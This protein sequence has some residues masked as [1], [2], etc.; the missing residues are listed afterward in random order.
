[1]SIKANIFQRAE[2]PPNQNDLSGVDGRYWHA[3]E[4]GRIQCDLCPRF[5]RLND[6]QRGLCFVRARDGDKLVLHSS[7]PHPA[8]PSKMMK[9]VD[10]WEFKGDTMTVTGQMVGPDGKLIT[11]MKATGKRK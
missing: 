10:T 8:D 9:T 7:G 11:M 3:L 1:M 6:G 2:A 4:D 5:C